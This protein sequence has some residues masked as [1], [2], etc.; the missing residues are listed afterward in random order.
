[1]DV[2][3]SRKQRARALEAWRA[4]PAHHWLA[5]HH[6]R[7]AR[8][9]PLSSTAA[10]A[11]GGRASFLPSWPSTRRCVSRCDRWR[12]LRTRIL[13]MRWVRQTGGRRDALCG[14]PARD[15]LRTTPALTHPSQRSCRD[16]V[17]NLSL[18]LSRT[19]SAPCGRRGALKLSRLRYG[20]QR[21]GANNAKLSTGGRRRAVLLTS[22][23]LATSATG[24]VPVHLRRFQGT[25]GPAFA[26]LVSIVHRMIFILALTRV[27]LTGLPLLAGTTAA[28]I[29]TAPRFAVV[30]KTHIKHSHAFKCVP[31]LLS[32]RLCHGRVMPESPA[33]Q[34]PSHQESLLGD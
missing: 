30:A 19:S 26:R 8:T 33:G 18:S 28:A 27:F 21:S 2:P 34:R 11:S 16:L 17:S 29:R 1:M 13:I 5:P 4:S 23:M 10:P 22:L 32:G 6:R 12:W 20:E 3:F 14:C 15:C 24:A 25:A 9:Y 7:P 31:R